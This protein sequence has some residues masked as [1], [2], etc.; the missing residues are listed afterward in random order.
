MGQI[1][2][3]QLNYYPCYIQAAAGGSL[4]YL[5]FIKFMIFIPVKKFAPYSS[6]CRCMHTHNTHTYVHVLVPFIG[7]RSSL[8]VTSLNFGGIFLGFEAASADCDVKHTTK[9]A[10]Q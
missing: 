3:H 8:L 10:H 4:N 2:G 6:R 5:E 9:Y 1:L 7:E